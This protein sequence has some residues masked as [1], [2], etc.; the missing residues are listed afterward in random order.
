M[1]FGEAARALSTPQPCD[2]QVRVKG[3]RLGR[4]AGAS[5]FSFNGGVQ[6]EQAGC[7]RIRRHAGGVRTGGGGRQ[8]AGGVRTG[9]RTQPQNFWQAAWGKCAAAAYDDFKWSDCLSGSFDGV[10]KRG[11]SIDGNVAEE[12]EREVQVVFAAPAR[13]HV[14]KFSAQRSDVLSREQANVARQF[15]GNEGA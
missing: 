9:V 5:A 11:N 10:R 4:E 6:R 3:A 2:C 13:A 14:G 12:F 1:E 7:L 15:D 8:H